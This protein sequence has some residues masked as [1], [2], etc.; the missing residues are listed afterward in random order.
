MKVRR[1]PV[2]A[3]MALPW[4]PGRA[5]HAAHTALHSM[6]AHALH[7][8]MRDAT[9]APC[10]VLYMHVLEMSCTRAMHALLHSPAA[11]ATGPPRGCFTDAPL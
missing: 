8:R 7:I 10:V 5:P 9:R 11:H 2:C 4:A 1:P 6:L 3:T